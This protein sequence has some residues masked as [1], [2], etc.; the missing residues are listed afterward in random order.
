MLKSIFF[1]LL[2]THTHTHTHTHTKDFWST[3]PYPNPDFG[4][5]TRCEAQS[6][7]CQYIECISQD[8]AGDCLTHVSADAISV[9][10]GSNCV[11]FDEN[12]VFG[13]THQFICRLCAYD[14][15]KL[16]VVI[17]DA[18]SVSSTD[19]VSY[20]QPYFELTEWRWYDINTFFYWDGVACRLCGFNIW[21]RWLGHR[22]LFCAVA[23]IR[24]CMH[25]V[26]ARKW[27]NPL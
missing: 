16:R 15:E 24:E 4:Y 5:T 13:V 1:P 20:Y 21:D 11:V 7:G 26:F 17:G 23:P 8:V 9:A 18:S 2:L 22:C 3:R 14:S 10:S 27:T 19:V 25:V 6:L 12:A